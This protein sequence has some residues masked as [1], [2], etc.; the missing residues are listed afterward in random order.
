MNVQLIAPNGQSITFFTNQNNS[1]G[2]VISPAIG[3]TGNAL[4]IQGFTTGATGN[5]G[6]VFGTT[7]E[8]NATRNIVDINPVTG[9]R[10]AAAP[11]I[12]DFQTEGG[13]LNAFVTTV[14]RTDPAAFNNGTWTLQITNF[15]NTVTAGTNPADLREFQLIFTKGMVVGPVQGGIASEFAYTYPTNVG[16]FDTIV[17]GGR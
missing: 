8:D 14:A 13:S 3:I 6:Q 7:F 10:G 4:G 16:A 9:A 2:T 11:F 1:A 12:G 5:P 17:V 15:S